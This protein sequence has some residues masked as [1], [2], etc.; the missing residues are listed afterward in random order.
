MTLVL[1]FSVILA[2]IWLL[3]TAQVSLASFAV[4][5]VFGYLVLSLIM[6]AWSKNFQVL[7]LRNLPDRLGALVI[8]G[9]GLY[10]DIFL[11][12]LDIA[13]RVL[14]VDMRLKPGIVAIATQDEQKQ[15]LIAALSAS[16]LS[17]T[18]GEMVVDIEDNSTL[19]IH[20]LDIDAT[21][22][23]THAQQARRVSL[24]KRI[25]GGEST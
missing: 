3:L 21:L 12:G 9:I 24:L 2:V 22:L 19:Y 16:A 11:S 4:G 18:P 13:R 20:T 15:T 10:R 8:Y 5:F 23:R 1:L 25:M 6:P 7:S 14:S 17:L